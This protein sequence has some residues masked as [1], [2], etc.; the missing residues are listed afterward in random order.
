MSAL[1]E[2]GC[3]IV[4]EE[5]PSPAFP[6]DPVELEELLELLPR[7]VSILGIA[8]DAPLALSAIEAVEFPN[9]LSPNPVAAAIEE[10]PVATPAVPPV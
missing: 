4:V 2:P 6:Y 7:D 1:E 5:V 9:E 8:V 10:I 3:R